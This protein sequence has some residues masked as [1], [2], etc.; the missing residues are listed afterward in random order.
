[1]LK[2]LIID[3]EINIRK[4]MVYCLTDAGHDAV[5]VSNAPDALEENRT[6]CFDMAFLDLRLGSDS[7]LELIPKLLADSPWLKIVIITAFGSINSAVEAIK[8]GAQDYLPK[9]FSPD[10]V[11]LVT[12]KINR[13]RSLERELQ[14]LKSSPEEFLNEQEV[15]S[16]NPQMQRLLETAK[17]AAGSEAN[18]L[19]LGESGTGKSLIARLI[20]RWSNRSGRP[21][22]VIACPAMPSELLESE[23]F[24]HSK[25]SFTGAIKDNP[26][27]IAACDGGT[28]FLD[29]IGDLAQPLQAKILRFIQ[30]REYERLGESK[31]RK[32]NVRIIAATNADLGRKVAEGQFREDLFYRLNVIQLVIPALRD[33]P[34]DIKPLAEGFI[35]HFC[36]VN[37]KPAIQLSPAAEEVLTRHNWPGNIRELKNAIERAIILGSGKGVLVP[38]DF[39]IL[40]SD[41]EVLPM[42]GDKITLAR[43]EE[44]HIRKILASESSLKEAARILGI[45]QATLWRRRKT[46]G[47]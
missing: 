39:S 31:V 10:Q 32:A 46:L 14:Q 13:L 7:G 41:K 29:E 25:G 45:D 20:H 8:L 5:A 42:V 11:R 21:F 23:L 27:K 44:L 30:D 19:L 43:L 18:L 35:R 4:T 33:R 40:D 6:A 1:M 2:I 37:N 38:L 34:E 22:A 16:R 36:L 15:S 24:G 12:E 9:P 17:I 26:G 47:I 3:D 28:L